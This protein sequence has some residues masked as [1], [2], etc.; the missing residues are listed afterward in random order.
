MNIIGHLFTDIDVSFY[1]NLSSD[2]YADVYAD[3]S[4]TRLNI[5]KGLHRHTGVE[6]L[7]RPSVNQVQL[8]TLI[9]T[10]ISV[11][12][13]ISQRQMLREVQAEMLP[14]MGLFDWTLQRY[15]R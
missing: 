11:T 9:I 8:N 1:T 5:I 10:D 7:T 4:A 12:I 6:L 14:L 15:D 13:A 3:V 2:L